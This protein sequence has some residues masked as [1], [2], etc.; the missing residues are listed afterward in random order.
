MKVNFLFTVLVHQ[1]SSIQVGQLHRLYL[2]P[3]CKV[4]PKLVK[5]KRDMFFAGSF[6]KSSTEV[7]S[8][9]VQLKFEG[10]IAWTPD[11]QD[12][13]PFDFAKHGK[14]SNQYNL[15]QFNLLSAQLNVNRIHRTPRTG[16]E[17]DKNDEASSAWAL[18][19]TAVSNPGN[20]L[21][22][23]PCYTVKTQVLSFME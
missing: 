16:A 23:T 8:T 21:C 22:K 11:Y 12:W 4:Q 9:E 20:V 13:L 15:Q 18:N 3:K 14:W 2:A 5:W 10:S 19:W 1:G 6:W 17:E 7:S